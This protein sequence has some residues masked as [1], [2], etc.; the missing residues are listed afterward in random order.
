[1]AKVTVKQ[2]TDALPV[3]PDGYS[4]SVEK[5]SPMVIKVWLNHPN[6]YTF[7]S[8]VRTIYCFLKNDKVHPPSTCDK[9]RPKSLCQI[10]ELCNQ[11][12]YTTI[13]PKTT[14]LLDLV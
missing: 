10:D 13:V 9:M 4:Y 6:E 8:D 3:A 5:V 12:P 11:S 1:M 14:N 7:K 2:V